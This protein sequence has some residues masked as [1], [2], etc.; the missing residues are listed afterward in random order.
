MQRIVIAL[1]VLWALAPG[2]T[3][4]RATP[5]GSQLVITIKDGIRTLADGSVRLVRPSAVDPARMPARGSIVVEAQAG[6]PLAEAL[7]RLAESGERVDRMEI[8]AEESARDTTAPTVSE[9]VVTKNLDSTSTMLFEVR[10]QAFAAP[11]EP[12]PGGRPDPGGPDGPKNIVAPPALPN[13]TIRAAKPLPGGMAKL[14]AQIVNAGAGPAAAT[15]VQ[16]YYHR[17]GTVETASAPVPALA[18]GQQA[19][20]PVGVN[21]PLAAADSVTLRVDDPN[22][23][24][25]TNEL[26]NGY[27]VP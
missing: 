21:L 18:S 25:E 26:D 14:H 4:G 13:L 5:D 17:G 20:V 10:Y 19:L 12:I 2:A 11:V 7:E 23:V 3:T 9:I 27:I 22:T 15:A 16:L 1:T 24:A 6:T 8:R